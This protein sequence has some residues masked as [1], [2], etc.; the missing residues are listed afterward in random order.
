MNRLKRTKS[1]DASVD[2]NNIN[3]TI[4]L[5]DTF[6]YLK[7][8]DDNVKS[9]HGVF[10]VNP[11]AF[12]GVLKKNINYEIIT[13]KL[14]SICLKTLLKSQ[15]NNLDT[16]N[17]V[18][19]LYNADYT[20]VD[21]SFIKNIYKIIDKLFEDKLNLLYIVNY[22]NETKSILRLCKCFIDKITYD[23]IILSDDVSLL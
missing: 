20:L 6:C 19:N 15:D 3:N 5:Y 13:K 10:I 12:T 9:N 4:L 22:N 11:G 17:V 23:K 21:I 1:V 2:K 18:I 14:I 16:F 7:N 8:D